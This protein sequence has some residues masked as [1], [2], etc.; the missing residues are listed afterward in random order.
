L[1]V[2]YVT[3]RLV[4]D[5]RIEAKGLDQVTLTIFSVDSCNETAQ[6]ASLRVNGLEF[7]GMGRDG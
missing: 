6:V 2:E 5:L 7:V 1:T 3:G 4:S